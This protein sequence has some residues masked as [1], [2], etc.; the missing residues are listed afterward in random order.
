MIG[1]CNADGCGAL[2]ETTI[3]DAN[4]P[5]VLCPDC[6]RKKAACEGKLNSEVPQARVEGLGGAL[7]L[8]Q[9]PQS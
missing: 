2:F 4:T 6:H 1:R 9:V 3:E 5:G 8:R 7:G